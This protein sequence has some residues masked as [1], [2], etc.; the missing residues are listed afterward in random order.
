MDVVP[1]QPILPLPPPLPSLPPSL[2]ASTSV[3]EKIRWQIAALQTKALLKQQ[4][5][6]QQQQQQG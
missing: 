5:M 2:P 4:R 6:Q 1:H 3:E